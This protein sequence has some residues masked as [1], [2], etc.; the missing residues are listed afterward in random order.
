MS[1]SR[2][3]RERKL[4]AKLHEANVKAATIKR[5][6]AMQNDVMVNYVGGVA[7]FGHAVLVEI[8]RNDF[9]RIESERVFV[10]HVLAAAKHMGFIEAH[11]GTNRWNLTH[12]CK[13][14]MGGSDGQAKTPGDGD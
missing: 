13:Q 2:K 5:Q 12:M 10:G 6:L 9:L 4:K 3:Q 1:R 14:L 7:E 8:A 11:Q